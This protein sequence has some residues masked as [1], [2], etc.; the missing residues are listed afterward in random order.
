M[1]LYHRKE[2]SSQNEVKFEMITY[3]TAKQ[4][5][6]FIGICTVHYWGVEQHVLGSVTVV[7]FLHLLCILNLV[8]NTCIQDPS[9]HVGH[10]DG[11]G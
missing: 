8:V 9:S 3:N 11:P 1:L 6:A 5:L 10:V 4:Q 7:T 2:R